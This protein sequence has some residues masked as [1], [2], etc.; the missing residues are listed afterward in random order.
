MKIIYPLLLLALFCVSFIK[1]PKPTSSYNPVFCTDTIPHQ[2]FLQDWVDE[3][4]KTGTLKMESEIL[5]VHNLLETKEDMEKYV[6]V[7]A[8]IKYKEQEIDTII[9]SED[10]NKELWFACIDFKNTYYGGHAHIVACK[11]NAK[12][13]IFEGVK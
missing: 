7:L 8:E 2:R 3:Y 9:I 5:Y 13:I 4:K 10:N 1:S 6:R 12:V 11:T